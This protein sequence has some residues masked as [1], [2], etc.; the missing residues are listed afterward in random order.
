MTVSAKRD[1]F[2]LLLLS[3]LLISIKSAVKIGLG[4]VLKFQ[5]VPN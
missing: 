2:H 3:L 4:I 1:L 5:I